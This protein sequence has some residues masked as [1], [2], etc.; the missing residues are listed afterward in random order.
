MLLADVR[1]VNVDLAR[2]AMK[3]A[4]ASVRVVVGSG[5]RP[6]WSR[7]WGDFYQVRLWELKRRML[8]VRKGVV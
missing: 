1:A 8:Q 2:R 4:S 5:E 6:Y 3:Y 7:V